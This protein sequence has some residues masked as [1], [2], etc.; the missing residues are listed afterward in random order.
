[1]NKRKTT[2]AIIA[3][4]GEC[5]TYEQLWEEI[6]QIAAGMRK[7]TVAVI[8]MEQEIAAVLYYLAC[9][10]CGVVPLLLHIRIPAQT[11]REYASAYRAEYLAVPQKYGDADWISEESGRYQK[12]GANRTYC[13]LGKREPEFTK[14]SPHHELGLL[15][16][17]SGTSGIAKT[18]RISRRNLSS[19]ARSI[20]KCL[21]IAETDRGVTSLP[22]SY[23]YGLSVLNTHLYRR[24]TVF[25]T[26]M[27]YWK[28][29][30]F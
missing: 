12:I 29:G 14:I 17:T 23:T 5:L 27:N 20:C 7:G 30:V 8:W 2:P 1:M 22:L 26:R 3:D 13:L 10:Y 16:T 19:N 21:E 11:V 9:L 4:T 24:A 6:R 18:V 28:N 25:L 15:L